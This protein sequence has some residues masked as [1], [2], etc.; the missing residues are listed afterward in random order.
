MGCLVLSLPPSDNASVEVLT[1]RTSEGDLI[2]NQ[3]HGKCNLLIQDEVFLEQ[4]KPLVQYEQ[5]PYEKE[6][7]DTDM[8]SERTPCVEVRDQVSVST[9]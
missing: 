2:W 9:S 3:D 5:Y 8:N 6:K 1:S 7:F 4:G